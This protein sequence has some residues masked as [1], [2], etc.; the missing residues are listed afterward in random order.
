MS[1][2]VWSSIGFL[3]AA[4][5]AGVAA[6]AI[7]GSAGLGIFF[8]TR[9]AEN[10]GDQPAKTTESE[11]PEE[12]K[13][14]SSDD[15]KGLTLQVSERE[16]LWEIEHHGNVLGRVAFPALTAALVKDDANELAALLTAD[17]KGELL[18]QPTEV[19]IHTDVVDVVRQSDSGQP[20]VAVE[21]ERFAEK[22]L[23]YR[24][25]FKGPVKAKLA[26]MKL[27]PTVSGNLDCLWEGTG[28]LR[29]WGETEPGQPGEITVYLKYVVLRPTKD[30]VER[31]GWMAA[32]AIT[33]SQIATAKHFLMKEV[34]AQRGLQTDR[35][36]DNW[37]LDKQDPATG[38]V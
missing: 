8:Y 25:L 11:V 12:N 36:Q 35:L 38:G 33:Q 29:L 16:Q 18:Q 22:L 3:T 20:P 26:L 37:K 23:E 5:V 13:T 21:R 31:G 4:L 17:F 32:C 7:V 27:R 14:P 24:R 19:T 9:N 6:V 34:A 30:A 28:Q 10:R 15:P 2:R 1:V